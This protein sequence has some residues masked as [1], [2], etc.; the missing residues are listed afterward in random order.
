MYAKTTEILNATGLHARPCAEFVAKA[1]TFASNVTIRKTDAPNA[2]N[3]K[4]MVLVMTQGFNKGTLVELSAEGE[5]EAQAVDALTA[6][7][8]SGFGEL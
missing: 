2:V 8:E 7:I 5:D 1:K 4:S 6:L 3:A